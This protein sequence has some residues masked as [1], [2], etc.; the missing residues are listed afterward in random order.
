M[1]G[2]IIKSP[3]IDLIL[4][5]KKTWEIRGSNTS[6]RGTIALIKS[7]SALILG[8]VDL[9]ASRKL[10]FE[11]FQASLAMHCIP[12]ERYP[13]IPYKTTHTWVLE[14]PV[15]FEIP[16]PYTHPQGAMIWVNVDK[17]ANISV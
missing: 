3:W 16:V 13:L 17:T 1:T 5:G 11:E 4:T 14:N 6:I 15:P 7:G 9:I 8:T 2:L 10:A 12:Q